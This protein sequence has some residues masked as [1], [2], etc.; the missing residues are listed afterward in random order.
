MA[1]PR[2]R[3][4]IAQR[5]CANK[6]DTINGQYH[7]TH[8]YAHF[9]QLKEYRLKMPNVTFAVNVSTKTSDMYSKPFEESHDTRLKESIL[10]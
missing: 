10:R 8:A 7:I 1:F 5:R 4:E 9:A 2:E 3:L 6:S